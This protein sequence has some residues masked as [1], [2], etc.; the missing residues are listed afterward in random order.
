MDSEKSNC[1]K[2]F[3]RLVD[4]TM[5]V[6][7]EKD[8]T[9]FPLGKVDCEKND[10]DPAQAQASRST[11]SRQYH[12]N[13]YIHVYVITWSSFVCGLTTIGRLFDK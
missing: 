8:K 2:Y 4:D 13:L 5:D 9:M 1:Y 6:Y 7:K 12:H 10:D 3:C 11:A